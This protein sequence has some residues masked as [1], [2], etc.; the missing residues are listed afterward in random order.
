MQ[1]NKGGS[2]KPA[3]FANPIEILK[4][5]L[6]SI[7]KKNKEKKRLLDQ[8]IRNARIIEEAFSTIMDATG[9]TNIDEIV[10]TFI[11][12]E[13]QNV[14]LFN[15][16]DQLN[17]ETDNLEE[18]NRRL[19]AEIAMYENIANMNDSQVRSKIIDMEAE[20][21]EK[22]EEI[23]TKSQEIDD[24]EEEFS[25]ARKISQDLVQQ[26]QDVRFNAKVAHKCQYDEHTVFTENNITLYLAEIEEYISSLIT[27]KAHKLGDPNA[28]ISSVPLSTLN[29]KNFTKEEMKI[30]APFD[31]T[32]KT[33]I[34]EE[35][36]VTADMK[37]L[38][39]RFNEKI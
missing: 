31:T 27:Y 23:M 30:D 16:V 22:R 13:E 25:E 32:V 3:E 6:T 4:I 7:Q 36:E 15:Y 33:A 9:I 19:D 11:K 35:E 20:C 10:T 1:D 39:Q 8:Y 28:A 38:Y 37:L 17:Q 26:F 2:G 5:R 29:Y 14:S 12:A 24:Q 18:E 34:D 21:A